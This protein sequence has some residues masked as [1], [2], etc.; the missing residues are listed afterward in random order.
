MDATTK[1]KVMARVDKALDENDR[2]GDSILQGKWDYF[3]QWLKSA[4]R[5]IWD[6]VKN[7]ASSVWNWV[8]NLFS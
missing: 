7:F 4:C 5:D 8:R 6:A 3:Y 1:A 2:L